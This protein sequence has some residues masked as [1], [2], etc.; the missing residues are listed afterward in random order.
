MAACKR[1]RPRVRNG[2]YPHGPPWTALRAS[3]N[4]QLLLRLR[5]I[6]KP[7]DARSMALVLLS[8]G[9]Y[10]SIVGGKKPRIGIRRTSVIELRLGDSML[11]HDPEEMVR[12]RPA[13]SVELGLRASG[14]SDGHVDESD[15][16]VR[17]IIERPQLPVRL[18]R[19]R[20][21]TLRFGGIAALA[22]ARNP[23]MPVRWPWYS[24]RSVSI[25][26]S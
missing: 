22:R 11:Q 21:E 8:I 9:E 2:R 17:V 23:S 19:H 20:R 4:A 25:S 5:A 12:H 10:L 18:E 15:M 24:S 7:I 16:I 14:V 13:D 3:I 26:V 1:A 6:S